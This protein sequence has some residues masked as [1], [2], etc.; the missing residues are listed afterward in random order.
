MTYLLHN[1]QKITPWCQ[2]IWNK[3]GN[4]VMLCA[5][6]RWSHLIRVFMRFFLPVWLHASYIITIKNNTPVS[7]CVLCTTYHSFC[8]TTF[9]YNVLP[10]IILLVHLQVYTIDISHAYTHY[11]WTHIMGIKHTIY[12]G[13]MGWCTCRVTF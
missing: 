5:V 8:Y 2:L 3:L 10:T 11:Y 7:Y 4:R 12:G 1:Y 9:C 13:V 6:S